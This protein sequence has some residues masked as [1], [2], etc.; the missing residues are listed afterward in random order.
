[1]RI[2][3]FVFYLTLF[4][5][6]TLASEETSSL[7]DTANAAYQAGNFEESVAN[8]ESALKKGLENGHLHYNLAN[9]LYRTEK[10]GEA[11]VHYRKA[12]KFLPSNPDIKY[13][14]SLARAET[15]DAFSEEEVATLGILSPAILISDFSKRLLFLV[16]LLLTLGTWAGA[17]LL[18][19]MRARLLITLG[20]TVLLYLAL[21]NFFITLDRLGNPS[22]ALS[23][24]ALQQEALVVVKP[25][26]LVYSGNGETF[27]VVTVLN[28]GAELLSKEKRE[29]W[30]RVELPKGRSGWVNIAD[31]EVV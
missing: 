11:I 19:P 2:L 18:P 7:I 9:A 14:L 12:L 21:I 1:M 4:P 27:Q 13:N 25:Q 15:K 31:V 29:N 5:S 28:D 26:A 8:Y 30:L 17:S 6:L 23:S 10:Y 16:C 20:S 3:F 22:L 24:S